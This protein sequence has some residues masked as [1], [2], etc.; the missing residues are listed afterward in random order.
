MTS[1]ATWVIDVVHD[2]VAVSRRSLLGGAILGG[3]LLGDAG[4]QSSGRSH[5]ATASSGSKYEK[6]LIKIDQ[7]R[8]IGFCLDGQ[9]NVPNVMN[10]IYL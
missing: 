4:L 1:H 5:M 3:T 2:C 8:P 9:L 10:E 6:V 7:G